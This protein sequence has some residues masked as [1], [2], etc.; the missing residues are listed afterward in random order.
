MR[1]QGQYADSGINAYVAAQMQ[2]MSGQRMDHKSGHFQ[3]R[4]EA[5]NSEKEHPY[6]TSKAEG[7]WRWERDGSKVSNSMSSNMFNEGQGGDD[8]PRS[9]YQGQRLDSKMGGEKQGN[10]DPRSLPHEE[11]MDIGY[12]ENSVSQTFEG[13]EQKFLDDI[14]KLT[15]EQSDAEDAGKC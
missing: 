6:A 1:R 11:D 5:L 4:P 13:L 2:H 7:R 10:S 8:A 3:G 9:F 14:R 15:K 12:E